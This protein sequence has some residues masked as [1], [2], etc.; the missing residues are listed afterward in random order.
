MAAAAYKRVILKLSGEALKGPMDYG[1]DP[2][3]I[4]SLAA[5]V[6]D[7]VQ[8]GVQLGI[9]VGGGNIFRGVAGQ[10]SGMN[11]S[12]ADHIG[13]LGTMIN[14]LSLQEAVERLGMGARVMSAIEMNE[15]AE[16]YIRRRAMAHLDKGLVVIFA[17]GTGNPYFSTDTAGALR[18]NEVEADVLMKATK[19]DGIY[20][21][22]PTR[23][24]NAAFLPE[25]SYQDFLARDLRAMDASAVALCRE[26][27]LPVLVFN[28]TKPGNVLRAVRGEKIGTIIRGETDAD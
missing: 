4:Q 24:P 19:V 2:A 5:Q 15:V 7:V 6:L 27:R 12:V 28:M 10:A 8:T 26:S 22:D 20:T 3:T 17:C 16:P 9:V 14:A 13:M 11:R 23:D 25:I 21:S 1:I 18:A